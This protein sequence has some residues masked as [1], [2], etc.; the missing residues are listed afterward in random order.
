MD[1]F[2]EKEKKDGFP[3]IDVGNM[4][5]LLMEDFVVLNKVF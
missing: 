2:W 1:L 3:I 5:R 4:T